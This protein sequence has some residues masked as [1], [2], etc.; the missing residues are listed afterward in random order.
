M[1]ARYLL[2]VLLLSG[3]LITTNATATEGENAFLESFGGEL[4]LSNAL[5][6]GSFLGNEFN[7][8]P[9]WNMSL[10]LSPSYTISKE[11]KV[12]ASFNIGINK[13]LVD[14]ADTLTATAKETNLTDISLTVSWGSFV[15]LK[16][17]LFKL[18]AYARAYFPTSKISQFMNRMLA[19]RL[20]LAASSKP[21][22]WMSFGYQ[23]YP[24]KYFNKYTNQVVD[25]SDFDLP[26]PVREGGA[27]DLGSELLATGGQVYEFALGHHAWTTFSFLS[28]FNLDIHFYYTQLFGYDDFELD[29]FS[30]S[31]AIAGRSYVDIMTGII[32]L[33]YKISDNLSVALG[34]TVEQTPKTSDNQDIRFPF[35]DTTNGA[36][37]R[38]TFYFDLAGSF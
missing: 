20:S 33:G 6:R 22:S 36:S 26:L 24:T 12:K 21:V 10:S 34:T 23:F 3:C 13:N 30:S 19:T 5:G 11:H 25:L 27:E 29:E 14:N 38:Q 2:S 32:E 31:N 4:V 37:N 17:G 16:D 8:R 9:Y 28:D 35:W 15:N 18:S 1:K 7:A